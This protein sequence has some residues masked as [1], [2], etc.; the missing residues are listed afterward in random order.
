MLKNDL[1][2]TDLSS[3][4]LAVL[5]ALPMPAALFSASA[6][7]LCANRLFEYSFQSNLKEIVL[8]QLNLFEPKIKS[9][10]SEFDS[11]Y[12][13]IECIEPFIYSENDRH[14][15]FTL[16]PHFQQNG[17]LKYVLL[18]CADITYLKQSE[19]KLVQRNLQLKQQV[20]FDH[21]TTV[22]NR[23]CFDLHLEKWQQKLNAAHISTLSVMMLDLDNFKQVND[24]YGHAFGDQV[25][26]QSAQI[27]EAVLAD[28]G[29]AKIYRMGGE[30]FAMILPTSTLNQACL[31]AQQCCAQIEASSMNY[32]E[33][34]L[35]LTIS[36]GVAAWHSSESLIET[37][38][39]ADQALYQAKHSSKNC[40]Y[41]SDG[42][43]FQLFNGEI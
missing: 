26:A 33:K 20:Y 27:L 17:E 36:C 37:L 24:D 21:L 3:A 23:R 10:V 25:L 19:Q 2:K 14:Y 38:V 8:A 32:T 43:S 35:K 5:E 16:K 28:I 41:F 40:T 30:E 22:R 42:Q 9:T 7:I 29:F 31:I 15:W 34:I 1:L 13:E 11:R 12:L 18:C 6:D 4:N 39:R